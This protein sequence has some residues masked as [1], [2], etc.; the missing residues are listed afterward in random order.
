MKLIV[1]AVVIFVVSLVILI[2]F[3]L[4]TGSATR[5][6]GIGVL[7]LDGIVLV[8]VGALYLLIGL[9]LRFAIR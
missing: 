7:K 6:T 1:R 2:A 4:L 9:I 3:R 8:Y 5:A